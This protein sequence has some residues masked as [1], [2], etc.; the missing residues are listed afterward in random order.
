M[1]DRI[2]QMSHEELKA[3]TRKLL[4]ASIECAEVEFTAANR[5]DALANA[6]AGF[7]PTT[8]HK[9]RELLKAEGY[10]PRDL[11]TSGQIF[12]FWSYKLGNPG[13]YIAT[14]ETWVRP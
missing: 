2:D 4:Q 7:S 3:A 12:E 6:I 11:N 14:K 10:S 8:L 9:V 1:Q 5:P 13:E